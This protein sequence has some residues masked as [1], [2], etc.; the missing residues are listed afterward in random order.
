MAAIPKAT[1]SKQEYG[2]LKVIIEH[3]TG[4]I[5]GCMLFYSQAQE[6]IG[7]IQLAMSQCI[8]L[9]KSLESLFIRILH[10]RKSLMTYL[11]FRIVTRSRKEVRQRFL[12]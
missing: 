9:M 4:K 1:I 12:R 2:L 7:I 8:L 6:L 5:L 10:W 11:I 3:K